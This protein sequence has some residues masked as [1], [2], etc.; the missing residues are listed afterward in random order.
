M[1]PRAIDHA[2]VEAKRLLKRAHDPQFT[3]PTTLGAAQDVVATLKGFPHWHALL[4]SSERPAVR[5]SP[6]APMATPIEWLRLPEEQR[7]ADRTCWVT[8]RPGCGKSVFFALQV[9]EHCLPRLENL[10]RLGMVDIGPSARGWV[11]ALRHRLPPSQ[12]K[13]VRHVVV[14]EGVVINPFD[15]PLGLTH[16]IGRDRRAKV[17][18]LASLLG[19]PHRPLLPSVA[20]ALL[21]LLYDDVSPVQRGSARLYR[22]G[23]DPLV[24]AMLAQRPSDAPEAPPV[25]WWDVVELAVQVN[26]PDLARRA[27][28]HAMPTLT[29]LCE[30]LPEWLGTLPALGPV[31]DA[32]NRCRGTWMDGI[33]NVDWDDAR[34]VVIDLGAVCRVRDEITE[35]L[36]G[37]S[38]LAARVALGTQA[39]RV[40]PDEIEG[41]DHWIGGPLTQ[42]RL[43]AWHQDPNERSSQVWTVYDEWHRADRHPGAMA[44]LLDDLEAPHRQVWLLTQH[45]E[46]LDTVDERGQRLRDRFAQGYLLD[47]SPRDRLGL[48]RWL[49]AGQP[50]AQQA[51]LDTVR[52]TFK[53]LR[54][55]VRV[56]RVANT[57]TGTLQER[58]RPDAL[59]L[60]SLSTTAE[61][62]H[63][64]QALALTLGAT[65]SLRLLARLFPLGTTC[66][67]YLARQ[68]ATSATAG[69][70]IQ[71]TT[72]AVGRLLDQVWRVGVCGGDLPDLN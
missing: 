39:G 13:L 60:W 37:S 10:P 8:G 70:E 58:P 24:D 22:K 40:D 19:Q 34:L 5:P 21:D 15:T 20:E 49:Y 11:D 48:Q 64:R 51:L 25:L 4:A 71:D 61:D 31:E 12:Q 44:Q 7:G 35:H 17:R 27:Q 59:T 42:S 23:V 46:G 3:L 2:R 63:L 43:Q 6:H 62:V 1:D 28:H 68:Q 53:A 26:R 14:D 54:H 56:Q 16:P 45:D 55:Q 32:L 69:E 41:T 9:M 47:V 67:A 65:T 18:W 72:Q 57:W 66:R 36:A 50:E 52:T 38:Y 29:R 33:T 30:R